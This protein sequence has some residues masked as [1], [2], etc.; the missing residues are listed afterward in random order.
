MNYCNEIYV[1][2]IETLNKLEKETPTRSREILRE[3]HLCLKQYIMIT[4]TRKDSKTHVDL[5][6]H[7]DHL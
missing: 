2:R 5:Q 1:T 7:K 6:V 4:N 3:V